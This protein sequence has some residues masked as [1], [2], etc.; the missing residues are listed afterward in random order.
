MFGLSDSNKFELT[1]QGKALL[2]QTVITDDSPGPILRDFQV[3]LDYIQEHEPEVTKTHQLSM[4]TLQPINGRLT[5]SIRH[6]LS[7]PTQKS[8][9]NVAGLYLILRASGLA[10]I[11]TSGKKPKLKLNEYVHSSWQTLNPTERYFTLLESWLLRGSE[12]LLG[13]GHRSFFGFHH[14]LTQWLYFQG[15]LR[16]PNW[17]DKTGN[18]ADELKY[19]PGLHNLALMESFGLI[20]IESEVP[21]E[22]GGW[23]ITAVE[24]TQYGVTLLGLLA[25]KALKASNILL[26]FEGPAQ[27]IPGQLQ[28]FIQ[29]YFPQWQNNIQWP[30]NTFRS[31]TYVFQVSL[32]KSVWRRIAIDADMEL[33]ILG[34]VILGAFD[35]DNDHLHRFI[36]RSHLG[37]SQDVNHP[38]MDEGP[39]TSEVRVGDVPLPVGGTMDFNFDFGDDWYF[40]VKLESVEAEGKKLKQSKILESHGK[41]PEQY[42]SYGDEW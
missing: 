13:E 21:A 25:E 32:S 10:F 17:P 2:Q 20:A 9:P 4:K 8:L 30:E 36:Y 23:W 19:L 40:K 38:Y 31:G 3:L 35:F 29:P 12:E 42:P 14:P 26:E 39:F 34:A 33:E 15:R 27:I 24:P 22:K 1:R 6:N 41:A 5:H 7:R 37:T 16:V 11:D 28:P 18:L